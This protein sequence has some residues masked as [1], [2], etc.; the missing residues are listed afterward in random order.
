MTAVAQVAGQPAHSAE[1]LEW[2][3]DELFSSDEDTVLIGGQAE[4]WYAPG[5]PNR[6]YDREDFFASALHESAH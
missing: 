2:L 3:F 4:P 6:L 1:Q 5:T